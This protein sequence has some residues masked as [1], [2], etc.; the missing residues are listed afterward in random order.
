MR[1][2]KGI[3]N[4]EQIVDENS[5]QRRISTAIGEPTFP[6]WR[7]WKTWEA[8]FQPVQGQVVYSLHL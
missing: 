1:N 7:E 6:Q 2:I 4:P 8:V 5:L 3:W